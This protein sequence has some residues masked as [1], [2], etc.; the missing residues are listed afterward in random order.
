MK[1]NEPKQ[2]P[3][4]RCRQIATDRL[5]EIAV[6]YELYM[7]PEVAEFTIEDMARNLQRGHMTCICSRLPKE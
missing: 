5:V 3:L 1:A 2:M 7:T 6:R 4:N